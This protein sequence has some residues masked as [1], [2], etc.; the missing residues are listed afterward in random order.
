MHHNNWYQFPCIQYHL[1]SCQRFYRKKIIAKLLYMIWFVSNRVHKHIKSLS[2]FVTLIIRM[3]AVTMNRLFLPFKQFTATPPPVQYPFSELSFKAFSAA[4]ANYS[5]LWR[6]SPFVCH[7]RVPIKFSSQPN[8][9]RQTRAFWLLYYTWDYYYIEWTSECRA[10]ACVCVFDIYIK[11]NLIES[12]NNDH[13]NKAAHI[14]RE[15]RNRTNRYIHGEWSTRIYAI[16]FIFIVHSTF[17]GERERCVT[18]FSIVINCSRSSPLPGLF[19]SPVAGCLSLVP[20]L[21]S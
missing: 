21:T 6:A 10:R 3:L 5:V 18:F 11:L 15:K 13:N 8:K 7:R 1:L 14:W 19:Q 4:A 20:S 12:R 9:S 16:S 2:F 17:Y